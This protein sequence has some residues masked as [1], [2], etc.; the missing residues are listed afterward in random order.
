MDKETLSIRQIRKLEKKKEKEVFK[1]REKDLFYK[2]RCL[3]L[4]IDELIDIMLEDEGEYHTKSEYV[5]IDTYGL[6]DVSA[7]NVDYV[8]NL[9]K[10][11]YN[12][13]VETN[14]VKNHMGLEVYE[15]PY[16]LM[17]YSALKVKM[18]KTNYVVTHLKRN[19]KPFDTDMCTMNV[20][21]KKHKHDFKYMIV[22]SNHDRLKIKLK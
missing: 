8:K 14:K 9:T 15:Y 6:I 4:N 5:E 7:G 16:V 10:T 17:S 21:V 1:E 12:D 19:D 2:L 22:E 11:I 20:E 18:Y 3:I 13:I